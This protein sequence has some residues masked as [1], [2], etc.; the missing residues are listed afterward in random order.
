MNKNHFIFTIWHLN[1]NQ[2][3]VSYNVT[4]HLHPA[5]PTQPNHPKTHEN[6]YKLFHIK[7]AEYKGSV[8]KV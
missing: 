7:M 2:I 5:A 4:L 6:A 1:R 3:I 8:I